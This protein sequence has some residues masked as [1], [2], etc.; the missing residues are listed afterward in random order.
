MRK[1]FTSVY[2]ATKFAGYGVAPAVLS[3][4]YG[5]FHLNAIRFACIAA[6]ILSSLLV[7]KGVTFANKTA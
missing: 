1:P 5:A 4:V 7:I 3:I 6:V 2:N